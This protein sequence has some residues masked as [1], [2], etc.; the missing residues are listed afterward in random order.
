LGLL[1]NNAGAVDFTP[2]T[3]SDPERLNK[4]LQLNLMAPVR[5]TQ[6][7]LPPLLEAQGRVIHI[8]SEV[9]RATGAFSLY[10]ISKCA[11][12]A[13]ADV[14]RQEMKLLGL[15]SILIRPGAVDTKILPESRAKLEGKL[16]T[17]YL[18]RFNQIA[19]KGMKNP[20]KPESVAELVY[21]AATVPNPK[22]VYGI[23]ENPALKLL[24]LLPAR[25]RDRLFLSMLKA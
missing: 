8:G 13:Y 9:V 24:A 11:L 5:L 10:G 19:P 17:K 14:C 7:F 1:V 4:L 2:V 23:G 12:A 16:F 21:R 3:E 25:L 15:H 20:V 22:S 18:E 6:A